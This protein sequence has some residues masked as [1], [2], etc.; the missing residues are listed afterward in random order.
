MHRHA[1]KK[2]SEWEINLKK[3]RAIYFPIYYISF[4]MQHKGEISSFI[5]FFFKAFVL[6]LWMN[7]FASGVQITEHLFGY[8]TSRLSDLWPYSFFKGKN[9]KHLVV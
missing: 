7:S 3:S 2:I 8:Y 6:K 1:M 4:F 9:A 5:S